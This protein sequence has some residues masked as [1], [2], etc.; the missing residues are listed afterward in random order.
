MYARHVPLLTQVAVATASTEALVRAGKNG[1]RGEAEAGVR[2]KK[3]KDN[4]CRC[5]LQVALFPSHHV[6]ERK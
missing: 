4:V 2:Q 1:L 3:E 6:V 5:G